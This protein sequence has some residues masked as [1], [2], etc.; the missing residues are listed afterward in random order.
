MK[1][2]FLCL[3]LIFSMLVLG[4]CFAKNISSA[5]IVRDE[6]KV[7]ALGFRGLENLNKREVGQ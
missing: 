5:N 2:K 7:G 6:A 4:G 3:L 1:K